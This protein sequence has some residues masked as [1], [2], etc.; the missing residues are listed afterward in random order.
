MQVILYV[1]KKLNWVGN[2]TYSNKK[3]YSATLNECV[4]KQRD[5]RSLI[6]NNLNYILYIFNKLSFS[7]G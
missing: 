7:C 3:N 2:D 1:V 6:I 5:Y 4:L